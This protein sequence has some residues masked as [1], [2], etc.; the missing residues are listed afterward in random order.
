[1][2]TMIASGI[3]MQSAQLSTD[4]YYSFFSV[5]TLLANYAYTPLVL[6]CI[7]HFLIS[8]F[9]DAFNS[10]IPFAV[11]YA[12]LLDSDTCINKDPAGRLFRDHLHPLYK[13][14]QLLTVHA[15]YNCGKFIASE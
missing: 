3:L 14:V 15:Y 12:V 5:V 7:I 6:F 2:R 1:M 9:H 11:I 13:L 8:L 10:L 4:F